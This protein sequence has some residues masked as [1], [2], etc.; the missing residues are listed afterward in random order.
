MESKIMQTSSWGIASMTF[1]E[2]ADPK[3][4]PDLF[5]KDRGHWI[6]LDKNQQIVTNAKKA[7]F[8]Q[9]KHDNWISTIGN[10]CGPAAAA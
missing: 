5:L 4:K 8:Q 10:Y 6:F 1:L 7:K 2:S 3:K 9:W